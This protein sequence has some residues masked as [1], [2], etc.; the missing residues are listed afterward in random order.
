MGAGWSFTLPDVPLISRNNG[1][2]SESGYMETV[3]NAS[4]S[5]L[6]LFYS[7]G[8]HLNRGRKGAPFVKSITS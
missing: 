6:P 1:F 7:S 2:T 8:A 4:E 3:E 5:A